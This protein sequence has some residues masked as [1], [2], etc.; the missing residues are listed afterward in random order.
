MPPFV[1]GG[2]LLVG[3]DD[4]LSD[5][6]DSKQSRISVDL[7]LTF[8]PT[9]SLATYAFRWS[10]VRRLLLDLQFYGFTDPYSERSTV[11]L[12]CQLPTDLRNISIV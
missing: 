8:H 6:F 1:G 3:K 5:H 9:P 12:C 7:P 11:P 4:L 2:G 10:E